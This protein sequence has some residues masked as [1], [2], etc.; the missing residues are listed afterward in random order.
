MS[1]QDNRDNSSSGAVNRRNILLAS[2]TLGVAIGVGFY[3]TRAD[4]PSAS[5]DRARAR[6]HLRGQCHVTSWRTAGPTLSRRTI[7]SAL[8]PG[9]H[10]CASAMRP[11]AGSPFDELLLGPSSAAWSREPDEAGRF[12]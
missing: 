9:E 10:C 6:P 2:T 3:S 1:S 4:N 8:L 7:S 12:M 11:L 5:A